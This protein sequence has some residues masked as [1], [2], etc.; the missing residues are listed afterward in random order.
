MEEMNSQCIEFYFLSN[1]VRFK[2][3]AL[4]KLNYDNNK[5]EKQNV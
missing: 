3:V 2:K 1:N 5:G 4:H